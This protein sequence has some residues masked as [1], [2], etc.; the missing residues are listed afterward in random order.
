MVRK[1]GLGSDGCQDEETG[2]ESTG[3]GAGFAV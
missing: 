3:L 1:R 2:A